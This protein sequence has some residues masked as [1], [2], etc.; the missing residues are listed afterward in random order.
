MKNRKIKLIILIVALLAFIIPFLPIDIHHR[1]AADYKKVLRKINV[2]LP[3]A[4]KVESW[5]NYDRSQSRW[6]CISHLIEFETTLPRETIENLENLCETS[7]HWYKHDDDEHIY[8]EYRSEQ[9]WNSDLYFLSCRIF[10]DKVM[11]EYYIDEDEGLFVI[12]ICFLLIFLLVVGLI[13]WAI[14]RL[15]KRLFIKKVR[16]EDYI[17]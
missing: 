10:D 8:Y 12:F 14:V 1:T 5:D 4:Y 7:R 16:K 15:V 17:S 2:E 13:I 6:D 3:N 11:I 9:E